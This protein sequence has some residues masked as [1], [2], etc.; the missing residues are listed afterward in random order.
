MARRKN[1]NKTTKYI[2]KSI[3]ISADVKVSMTEEVRLNLCKYYIEKIVTSAKKKAFRDEIKTANDEIKTVETQIRV[4]K[5]IKSDKSVELLDELY[6]KKRVLTNS[7]EFIEY[8]MSFLSECHLDNTVV[9]D[10][11]YNQK[12]YASYCN[13]CNGSNLAELITNTVSVLEQ[14][15]IELSDAKLNEFITLVNGINSRVVLDTARLSKAVPYK[16][17]LTRFYDTM[18]DFMISF[19]STLIKS[20]TDDM[21]KIIKE[22]VDS[23]TI[24]QWAESIGE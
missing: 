20:V 5:S 22:K 1:T 19:N 10:N 23:V 16:K 14:W 9:T 2:S 13:V 24:E 12:M 8:K 3:K 15:G 6:D 18:I 17:Y 21:E 11:I 7:I 4:I